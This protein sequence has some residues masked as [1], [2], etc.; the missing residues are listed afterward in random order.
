MT[1]KTAKKG[2]KKASAKSVSVEAGDIFKSILDYHDDDSNINKQK[3][4]NNLTTYI[5]Q[6]MGGDRIY[7]KYNI[8]VLYD[9][10]SLSTLH[11][12]KIYKTLERIDKD[13]P[14]ILVLTSN[15]GYP[16]PAY[17]IGKL[18]QQF[19]S[20][21][22]FIVVIPRYAKS[23]ATLLA[24]AAD[25]V[26]MGKLSELGPIDPQ[27]KGVPA[28]G[29]KN[30]IEHIAELVSLNKDSAEMFAR[31]LALTVKPISIGHY[32][33]IA[34]ST[35]QYA[36]RLLMKKSNIL[37]IQPVNIGT[38]LV[39]GYKDHGFVIDQEEAV[40]IFGDNFIVKESEEYQFGDG[41]YQILSEFNEIS[42]IL[43]IKF[44]FIGSLDDSNSINI[45]KTK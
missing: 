23:A 34:E 36:S 37:K 3:F 10:D 38:R 28:L 22:D 29:L 43:N 8:V 27:V 42:E 14:I 5:Q 19:S 1:K 6:S 7:K 31:Y 45:S 18:F 33:R 4:I 39:Y 2:T 24:C 12:D 35:V 11:S 32:E 26:H 9:N 21:N 15:G 41:I 17:L 40:D 13:K 16:S 20:E 25:K 30:S 44:S